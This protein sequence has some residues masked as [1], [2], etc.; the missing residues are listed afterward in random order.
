MIVIEMMYIGDL[1]EYLK[2]LR[3]TWDFAHFCIP[4]CMTDLIT[5]MCQRRFQP[6]CQVYCWVSV[7]RLPQEWPTSVGKGL[8][9]E[10]WLP[11]IFL[12]QKMK[13][14][15]KALF[16]PQIHRR[17]IHV[18]FCS[19]IADFGL[20]RALQ[21][22]DYYVSRGGKIPVK[23]TAPEALS[24][25]KYSTASDVWSFGV[26]LYEI[27]SLGEK[28]YHTMSNNEVSISLISRFITINIVGIQEGTD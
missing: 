4:N 21:D 26:V 24:Y 28:P 13:C 10:T 15:R 6:T 3:P 19:K 1:R 18:T 11:G 17:V 25:K 9:I 22:A 16:L 20:S 7:V 2:S 27:W 5:E 8:F 14:A 23:W 12:C